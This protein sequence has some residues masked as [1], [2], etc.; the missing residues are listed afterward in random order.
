VSFAADLRAVTDNAKKRMG[1][2]VK[3]TA[4]DMQ[5]AMVLRAPV[6]ET[7]RLRANFQCGIGRINVSTDRAGGSNPLPDTQSTLSRWSPGQTIY[8]TNSIRYAVVAEYGLYG[9]PP[10][11]ANGPKTIAGYSSQAV[12]G[13]VRLTVQDFRP[14]LD[15]AIKAVRNV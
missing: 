15:K 14:I 5:S 9:K 13:F 2:V 3:K 7:G 8:L 1:D 12:G 11:S 10:G 6:G 4:L